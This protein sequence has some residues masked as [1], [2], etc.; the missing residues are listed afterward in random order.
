MVVLERLNNSNS[1]ILDDL[2]KESKRV[3]K[4]QQDFYRY[5]IHRGSIH[6]FFIRKSVKLLKYKDKYIGYIWLDTISNKSQR[7]ND[8]YIAPEH[9][10]LVNP[11]TLNLFKGNVFI[12]EGF[13]TEYMTYLAKRLDMKMY[14]TTRLMKINNKSIKSDKLKDITYKVYDKTTDRNV[15]CYI[16]NEVFGNKD[17]VPLTVSDIEFDESQ[18]Y[19]IN[20]YCIFIKYNDM[21][22]G[23]GQIVF[24]RGQYFIVNLGIIKNYRGLGFGKILL[25]KLLNV[26]YK[27]GIEDVYIRVE[28][29]NKI[30]AELYE[31]TGFY[32]VG[33]ISNWVWNRI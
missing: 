16:Q 29:D 7:I 22:I 31:E 27:D 3:I 24:N 21:I 18:E 14:K 33:K 8:I 2:L 13:E 19:Y 30:A 4:Y 11:T 5:Y 25:N 1:D 32:D 28:S 20:D 10:D 9:L 6:R 12:Y 17:R 15:R 23:Y 26:A